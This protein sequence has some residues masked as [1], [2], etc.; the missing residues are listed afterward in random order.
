METATDVRATFS[1]MLSHGRSKAMAVHVAASERKLP[2][3]DEMTLLW[4]CSFV[5]VTLP[6]AIDAAKVNES[7]AFQAAC[8][9]AARKHQLHSLK[10]HHSLDQS[11]WTRRWNKHLILREQYSELTRHLLLLD[12]TSTQTPLFG[13]RDAC[14]VTAESHYSHKA[15]IGAS[16]AHQLKQL[17]HH[18]F[19]GG[20]IDSLFPSCHRLR[21]E[22]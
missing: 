5:A 7:M 3:A 15:G 2:K 9:F 22:I 11:F 6:Q 1:G 18:A 20:K 10:S 14:K 12:S 4:T 16:S 21:T 13:S 17:P 19:L 8:M